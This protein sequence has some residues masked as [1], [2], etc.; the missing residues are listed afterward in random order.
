M[1]KAKNEVIEILSL[2]NKDNT[3]PKNVKQKLQDINDILNNGTEDMALRINKI[4]QEL[5]DLSEES[6]IPEYTRTQIWNLASLL[7]TII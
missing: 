1:N 6:N 2:M 5:D 7:E 4:L 3:V